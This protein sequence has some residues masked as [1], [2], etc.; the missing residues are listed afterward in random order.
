MNGIDIAVQ[1]A[2]ILLGVIGIFAIT[3]MIFRGIRSMLRG[4][5]GNRRSGL[6]DQSFYD[7]LGEKILQEEISKKDIAK[8]RQE[9]LGGVIKEAY[10]DLYERISKEEAERKKDIERIM[11][12]IARLKDELRK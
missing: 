1:E 4:W 10:E 7:D 6:F 11:E 12:E 9:M 5:A 3:V 8:D 2:I